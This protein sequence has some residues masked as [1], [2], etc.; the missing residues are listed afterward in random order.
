[1]LYILTHIHIYIKER[2]EVTRWPENFAQTVG[3]KRFLQLQLGENVPDAIMRSLF[4]LTEEKAE[5]GESAQFV[6]N[7][8]CMV[9]SVQIHSVV[10]KLI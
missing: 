6:G 10:L 3:I 1:M 9:L 4:Q 8:H 7:I 5:K 2:E